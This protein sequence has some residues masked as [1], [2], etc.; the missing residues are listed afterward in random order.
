MHLDENIQ[1]L[2]G[3]LSR[4]YVLVRTEDVQEYEKMSFFGLFVYINS[5]SREKESARV[6]LNVGDINVN[7]LTKKK[8]D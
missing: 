8:T 7:I 3:C 2:K 1:S 6:L 5:A 4:S